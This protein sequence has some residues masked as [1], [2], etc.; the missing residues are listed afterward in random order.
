MGWESVDIEQVGT[1]PAFVVFD[2]ER[3]NPVAE[4]RGVSVSSLLHQATR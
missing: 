3:W 4:T 2:G 1:P